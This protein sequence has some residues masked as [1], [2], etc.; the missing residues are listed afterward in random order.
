MI[1]TF[2]PVNSWD[3]P[4]LDSDSHISESLG[5]AINI[6]EDV[7]SKLS[8]KYAAEVDDVLCRFFARRSHQEY[9]S[10]LRDNTY[11]Q[12]NDLDSNFIFEIFAPVD[13]G[14]W[15]YSDDVYVVIERHLG[16]DVRGNYGEI[17]VYCVDKI[18]ESGFF[19]LVC[20]WWVDPIS[21]DYDC[22]L[23][24]LNDR[25]CVGYSSWP[26]GELRDRLMPETEPVWCDRLGCYVGRLKG[27][28]FP[29][30]MYSQAPYYGG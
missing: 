3:C 27:V 18:A 1:A 11:N 2:A 23:S 20:G 29:V 17:E 26:T 25:L 12:E 24:E 7:E 28:E 5:N 14:D 15:L 13:C 10:V 4:T 30:K 8:G 21:E 19:D 22:D 6:P 9:T 16:G